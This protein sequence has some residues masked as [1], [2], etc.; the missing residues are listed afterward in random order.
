MLH[1]CLST[2]RCFVASAYKFDLDNSYDRPIRGFENP[3][4][5]EYS[6]KILVNNGSK[7]LPMGNLL[8]K[9]VIHYR[10]VIYSL[11]PL[12]NKIYIWKLI[13]HEKQH[14]N[15]KPEDGSSSKCNTWQFHFYQIWQWWKWFLYSIM[16]TAYLLAVL[17][18]KLRI[19]TIITGN[20]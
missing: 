20:P 18:V 11:K 8:R 5:K 15:Y 2:P 3:I 16:D 13:G 10:L 17:T 12:F 19:Q 9:K 1:T 14:I 4:I 7:R 6:L